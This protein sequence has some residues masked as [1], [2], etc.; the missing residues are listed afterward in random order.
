M[1]RRVKPP[2]SDT[3]AKMP[4][5]T[6]GTLGLVYVDRGGAPQI[7]MRASKDSGRTWPEESQIVLGQHCEHRVA[8]IQ[9]SP[10]AEAPPHRAYC[11]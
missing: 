4:V 2:I 10:A 11:P 7:G 5:L 9:V 3:D 1:G 8:A 6:D